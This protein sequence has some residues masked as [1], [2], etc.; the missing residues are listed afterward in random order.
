MNDPVTLARRGAIGILTIARPERMNALSRD[1]VLALGRAARELV[2]DSAVRA[3]VVT[4]AGDKAFCAGADLKE[5]RG[6]TEDE[7][8]TQLDP[9]PHPNWACSIT[10][11]SPW[12]PP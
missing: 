12:S 4:G 10:A 8:R 6:M 3:I 5:R 2:S 11:P 9:L 1:V 7:V